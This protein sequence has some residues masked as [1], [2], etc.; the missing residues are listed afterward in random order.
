MD[1]LK[2]MLIQDPKERISAE[3]ALSSEYLREI[4]TA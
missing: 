3:M 4:K 1:L 2:K